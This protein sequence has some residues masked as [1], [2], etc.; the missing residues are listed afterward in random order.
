M[1]HHKAFRKLS[2]T[3]SHRSAMFRN[4]TN[5]LIRHEIITTTLP[6]AKELRRYV[7]P[8]ITLGKIAN[9][10]NKRTV[11][12]RLRDRSNVNKLFSE[13]GPRYSTRP[14]GYMRIL[15]NGFRKG[16]NAPM[17]VVELVDRPIIEDVLPDENLLEDAENK[18]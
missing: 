14:G 12:N 10:N 15:K 17:A 11:F 18:N 4:M 6:K 8:I 2:R 7:E 13:L 9:F 1:R 16:D 5:S 3:S